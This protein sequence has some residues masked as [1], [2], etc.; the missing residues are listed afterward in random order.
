MRLRS[1]EAPCGLVTAPFAL[2]GSSKPTL[3]NSWSTGLQLNLQSTLA[4]TRCDRSGHDRQRLRLPFQFCR[5]TSLCSSPAVGR[6]VLAAAG[7]RVEVD[8]RRRGPAGVR[9]GDSERRGVPLR[10]EVGRRW[11][12]WKA[13]SQL[14]MGALQEPSPRAV[15]GLAALPPLQIRA[16][17]AAPPSLFCIPASKGHALAATPRC[18]PLP[19]SWAR[20]T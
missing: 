8:W 19:C 2:W 5:L 10:I 20:G 15:N 13:G 14:A 12:G 1:A 4:V 7:V 11:E 16:C 18:A 6:D 17:S 3:C 9:F